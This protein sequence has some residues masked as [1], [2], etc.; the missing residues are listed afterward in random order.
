MTALLPLFFR[1]TASL[2]LSISTEQLINTLNQDLLKVLRTAISLFVLRLITLMPYISAF[3]AAIRAPE[4]VAITIEHAAS[5]E[6]HIWG[7][8]QR[9]NLPDRHGMLFSYP[10]P[11][12]I[13]LWSFNC[14]MDLSLAFLDRFGVIQ[15]INFLKAYPEIM[16][17]R[18]PV[19]N[20][21]E[22]SRYPVGDPI[23]V[24]FHEH[25][26]VSKMP[27]VYALEMS[28]SFF[29]K[30]GID[31]GNVLCWDDQQAYIIQAIDLS[32]HIRTCAMPLVLAF[33][34]AKP[35]AIKELKC[36]GD[37]VIN[38]YDRQDKLIHRALFHQKRSVQSE[39]IP[40]YC[41]KPVA[42]ISVQPLN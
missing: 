28:P 39:Q 37:F 8:M 23:R 22:F 40:V 14:Y 12:H 10:E 27:C 20:L 36:P 32:D 30:H 7:L 34:E 38:F 26:V 18:R 24:F 33:E 3:Q 5:D 17:P 15:E 29:G 11:R 19:N 4:P 1:L 31:V 35:I 42:R 41:K 2:S 25:Q 16:D 9:K 6:Q 21:S 13:A